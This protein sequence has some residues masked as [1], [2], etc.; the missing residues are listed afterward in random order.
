MYSYITGSNKKEEFFNA[1]SGA[2]A[3]GVGELGGLI[4]T[5]ICSST[6]TLT[7]NQVRLIALAAE[8]GMHA[9]SQAYVAGLSGGD[10]GQGFRSA[11]VSSVV[12]S[13]TGGV[14]SFAGLS[15]TA[16]DISTMLF[17]FVSGGLSAKL[18]GGN[19][20]QGA[21]IGLT[22][23]AL[24]HVVHKVH[25]SIQNSKRI[26]AGIYGVGG[27]EAGGNPTLKKI[28]NDR[29]GKMFTS[30][31]SYGDQEILD[32][33]EAGYNEGKSVE[34]FGYSRGGNAAVRITN[35]LGEKGVNVSL[36]VT[37]DPHSLM[38]DSFQLL[39]NNVGAAFNF[40]QQNLTSGILG[41][42]PYVGQAVYSNY[43]NVKNHNFYGTVF[44][45][46]TVNVGH[47]NIVRY[48]RENYNYGFLK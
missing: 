23:S 34:I 41:N 26:V 30:S 12:A 32:Y 45:M 44:P 22:V 2:A 39:Y 37:F 47:I 11:L 14:N 38:D 42:N 5:D 24:N 18:T 33:L 31:W 46:S 7:A 9:V 27:D 13:V 17:G 35:L 36:L 48:V 28:V 19:F 21:A 29:G 6:A 15:G 4:F 8:G 3:Y 25:T 1:V 43:I 40:F 10:A 16:G 20:W